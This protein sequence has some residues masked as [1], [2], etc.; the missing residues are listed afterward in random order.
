MLNPPVA[1]AAAGFEGNM[2]VGLKGPNAGEKEHT[3]KAKADDEAETNDTRE[4][5]GLL[6]LSCQYRR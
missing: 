4:F 5:H 2:V 1:G 3:E 6:P